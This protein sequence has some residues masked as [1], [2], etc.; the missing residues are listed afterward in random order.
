MKYFYINIDEDE[1][2]GLQAVSLVDRPAIETDFLK[3]KDQKI[4][5]AKDEAKHIISGPSLVANMPIYRINQFTGEEY[6]VIFTKDVIEKL[7]ERYSKQ[8]LFNSVNL[9]HNPDDY[10]D[11]VVLIES[12][13]VN[14]E[15]GIA[16]KEYDLEDG[17]WIT[18]YKIQ[19]DALWNEIMTT[20]EFKGFSVEV[21]ANLVE[22]LSSEKPVSETDEINNLIDELLKK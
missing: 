21:I 19:D 2:L 13:F 10:T 8:N 3:F 7:V 9:Q 12:Y 14:K 18:S 1:K 17:S 4:T 22:K 15:R 5:F 16:P 6:Y 11:K 20:D